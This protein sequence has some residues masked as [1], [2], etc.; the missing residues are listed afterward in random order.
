MLPTKKAIKITD[1]CLELLENDKD[2]KRLEQLLADYL[3][4]YDGHEQAMIRQA[5]RREKIRKDEEKRK[6]YN[7]YHLFYY[8]NVV[9]KKKKEQ[10]NK[11]H[12]ITENQENHENI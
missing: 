8:H 11:A 9:M 6:E 1:K 10:K 3:F 5:E 7:Q 4:L 2:K 12:E